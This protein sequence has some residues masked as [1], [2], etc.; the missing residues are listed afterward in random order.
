[1]AETLLLTG[2]ASPLGRAA[3]AAL[4]REGHRLRPTDAVDL[5][6][7]GL[8]ADLVRGVDAIVHLAPLV[9]GG[10]DAGRTRRG[11]SWTRPPAGRTSCSRAAPSGGVGRRRA[12]PAPWPSLDA[13]PD[14]LEVTEQWRPR[15]RP[16]PARAGALP[17][18]ADRQGVHPRR[19]ARRPARG[20]LPALRP[21]PATSLRTTRAGL[22][23]AVRAVRAGPRRGCAKAGASAGHR[24]QLFHVAAPD[25][26]RATA[27]RSP[28]ARSATA[29]R[30][31]KIVLYGAGGPVAA[32][33]IAELEQPTPCAWPTSARPTSRTPSLRDRPER[34]R[35][36]P[37]RADP[38]EHEFVR[39]GRHRPGAGPRGR[40]GH[41][42]DRQPLASS[43]PTR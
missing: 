15:P 24:L 41:G 38:R 39:D 42:R 31:V 5:T 21:T 2:A 20:R 30:R 35:D 9:P 13:Y 6:D 14:D 11:R 4:A 40:R 33:A 36:W 8:A 16:E 25:P 10:D 17:G 1:M 37:R 22:A 18:G 23:D 34:A 12:R 19:P 29:R 32:A 43:A 28:S 26:T 27:P 7:P 3:A